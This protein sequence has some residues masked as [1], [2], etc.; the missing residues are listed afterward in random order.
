MIETKI[1]SEDQSF[2]EKIS[3]DSINI[4]FSWFIKNYQME[5]FAIL[6][7]LGAIAL[8]FY[9]K[10]YNYKIAVQWHRKSLPFIME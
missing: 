8:M 4:D 7:M 10:S 3:Q 1:E 9:G 5:T 6:L 2:A